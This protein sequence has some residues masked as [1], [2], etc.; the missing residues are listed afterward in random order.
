MLGRRTLLSASQMAAEELRDLIQAGALQPGQRVNADELA[1]SLSISRTPVRDALQD[2]RTE[3][4]V[5]ILPR[6]GIF[7]RRIS[8]DEVQDVYAIKTAIEPVAAA[9]AAERAD[10]SERDQLKIHMLAFEEAGRDE[11]LR[12]CAEQV[13]AIH[14]QLFAMA[15]S[16]VLSDVYR[17][18]H[19]RV[20]L[21]RSL[22][23]GQPGR[24][25]A[26][27]DQHRRVVDHVVAQ[28]PQAAR[29]VMLQHMFD[30]SASV[31]GLDLAPNGVSA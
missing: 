30:A 8:R 22:N 23:M 9:W 28:E 31:M 5:E 10:N 20:R 25:T 7:V 17:V 16:E 18:F 27:L 1:E 2:L 3:G 19:T 15:H 11:D 29:D 24:L 14:S 6:R 21:L 26:S 13:D 12:R 4:L